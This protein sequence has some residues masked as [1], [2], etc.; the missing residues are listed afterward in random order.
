MLLIGS[1][2]HTQPIDD[3]KVRDAVKN[4]SYVWN[5]ILLKTLCVQTHLGDVLFRLKIQTW[6]CPNLPHCEL[7][8]DS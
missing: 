6:G 2:I 4:G 1:G 5:K 7:S 8:L 3:S